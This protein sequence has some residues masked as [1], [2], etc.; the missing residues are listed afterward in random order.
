MRTQT[1]EERAMTE[2]TPTPKELAEIRKLTAEA[3]KLE[4]DIALTEEE[5]ETKREERRKLAAEA[6][7]A[8]AKAE[9]ARL[10]AETYRI[11]MEDRRRDHDMNNADD[12]YHK[13]YWF[14]RQVDAA[15]VKDCIRA[16]RTWD[17][18]DPEC[19]ITIIF[20]SPGGSVIHGMALFDEIVTLSQRGGG[21]HKITTVVRGYAASMGGILLQAGDHRVCGRESYVMIHEI[22]A[23]TGGKIGEIKDDVKFYETI[24]DRIVNLF[25]ER[26]GG[27]IAKATFKKN[28]ERKDWWLD[29]AGALK[30]G[31]VDEVK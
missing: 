7:H 1:C 3:D 20:N 17:R 8:Q 28:W 14:D 9:Q 24:S 11:N 21:R 6:D 10:E 18:M 31:F 15:T 13:T 2:M 16:L 30:Y 4:R 19:D 26:S 25:V 22:A 27:K 5:I 12:Y 23:G 29:S